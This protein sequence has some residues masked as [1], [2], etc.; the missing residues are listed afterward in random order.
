MSGLPESSFSL[1]PGERAGN[2]K[3]NFWEI[4]RVVHEASKQ[5]SGLLSVNSL[6]H[7]VLQVS[8]SAPQSLVQKKAQRE[9]AST[10]TGTKLVLKPA[11]PLQLHKSV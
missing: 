3:S 10:P 4:F 5:K 8:P 6:L 9:L 11:A 1:G 2:K 7:W